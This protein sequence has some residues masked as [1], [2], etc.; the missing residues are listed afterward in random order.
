MGEGTGMSR[1]SF[2]ALICVEA[3]EGRQ[4]VVH[5]VGLPAQHE[6]HPCR[7]VG[8]GADEHPADGRPPEKEAVVGGELD[9]LA[10]HAPD[11]P[12]RPVSHGIAHE[13]GFVQL[14]R[15]NGLEKM[16]RSGAA[17]HTAS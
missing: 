1:T 13:R 12:V 9:E 4:D 11:P 16:G 8:R 17:C 5:R 2:F 3:L 6:I 14:R 15:R 10:G 7:R